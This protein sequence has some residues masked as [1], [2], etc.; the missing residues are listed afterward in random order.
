MPLTTEIAIE[1][2][3]YGAFFKNVVSNLFETS[4]GKRIGDFKKK[5]KIMG[6]CRRFFLG[7]EVKTG[8]NVSRSFGE[9]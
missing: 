4:T 2:K 6:H 3:V 9:K 1:L 5:K 7:V 8:K